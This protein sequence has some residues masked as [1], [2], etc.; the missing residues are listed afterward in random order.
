MPPPYGTPATGCA[1]G[2]C[3]GC[4]SYVL[5]LIVK[6]DLSEAVVIATFGGARGWERW[7]GGDL[8]SVFQKQRIKMIVVITPTHPT[9]MRIASACWKESPAEV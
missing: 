7:A 8:K 6:L 4:P 3:T 9:G 5:A 2:I 1:I